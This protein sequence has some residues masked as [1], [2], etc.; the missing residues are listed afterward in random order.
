MSMKLKSKGCNVYLVRSGDKR[1]LIDVG[2]DGKLIAEQLKELDG[3]IITHAHF[4]HI[5]GARELERIFGCPFF[6]HP[7]ELPYVFKEREFSFTGI[8]GKLAKLAE[9]MSR[10]IPP[11]NV[12]S[13]YELKDLRIMHTPGH[14]PGSICVLHEGKNYCGD[15]LRGNA[16]LS[17][18]NFCQSYERY[19]ESVRT[20]LSLDWE[21]A[22]PGHGKEVAKD[23]AIK[24]LQY[25]L[26]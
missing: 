18:K 24:K 12:R 13:V 3:V 4:D 15:L 2:T 11:E 8:M 20:V 7:E 5:A 1:Y 26:K 25:L 17:R 14:T 21:K 23:V 10:F 9:R 16:K 6:A 22:F 19:L